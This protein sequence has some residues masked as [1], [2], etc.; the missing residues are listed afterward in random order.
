MV[1][2]LR[3]AASGDRPVAPENVVPISRALGHTDYRN[4]CF[5]GYV[6]L[7]VKSRKDML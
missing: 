7:A 1:I 4:T 3:R 5:T 2:M 6:A